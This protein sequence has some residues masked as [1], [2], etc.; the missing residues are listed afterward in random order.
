MVMPEEK[1][2]VYPELKDSTKEATITI[3]GRYDGQI[4]KLQKDKTEHEK[5][6][7][8]IDAKILA[9]QAKIDELV[10]DVDITW[11]PVSAEE[12]EEPKE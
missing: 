3:H 1:P 2:K 12:P 11:K 4:K 5:A 7:V 9:L 10:E 6:I 8:A